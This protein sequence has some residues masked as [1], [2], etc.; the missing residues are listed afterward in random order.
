LLSPSNPVDK[1]LYGLYRSLEWLR[2]TVGV[3]AE[4]SGAERR[5]QVVRGY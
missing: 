3:Q 4:P 2:A 1:A 5:L